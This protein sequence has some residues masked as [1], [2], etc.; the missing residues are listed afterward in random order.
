MGE[1]IL[2]VAE[3]HVSHVCAPCHGHK[4]RPPGTHLS[5]L[6]TFRGLGGDKRCMKSASAITGSVLP[7]VKSGYK[8]FL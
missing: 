4:C 7:G 2:G 5:G 6:L 3:A 1:E 8:H